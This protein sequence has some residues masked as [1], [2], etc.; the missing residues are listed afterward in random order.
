MEGWGRSSV[1]RRGGGGLVLGG[2][3]SGEEVERGGEV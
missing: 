1:R 2:E 3:A